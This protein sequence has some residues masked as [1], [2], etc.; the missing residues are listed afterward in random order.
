MAKTIALEL[1]ALLENSSYATKAIEI[2]RIIKAEDGVAV[3][4]DAIEKQ[5]EMI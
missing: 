4:Y 2:G 5:L 3:A 1:N